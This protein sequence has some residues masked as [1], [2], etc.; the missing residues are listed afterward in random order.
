M[1]DE[2]GEGRMALINEWDG[3]SG[4]VSNTWKPGV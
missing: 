1:P 2:A 3:V 4:M